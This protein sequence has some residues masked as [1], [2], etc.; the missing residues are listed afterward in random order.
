MLA[1][2]GTAV[3]PQFAHDAGTRLAT[4]LV[5][6]GVDCQEWRLGLA[7][8]PD[9]FVFVGRLTGVYRWYEGTTPVTHPLDDPHGAA[10]RI[11]AHCSQL[12]PAGRPSAAVGSL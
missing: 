12:D 7:A 4:E 6:R 10:E 9:L 11:A 8:A 1:P 3:T 5:H 2:G